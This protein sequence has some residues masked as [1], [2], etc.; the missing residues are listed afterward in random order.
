G[1]PES[2]PPKGVSAV[3][4]DVTNGSFYVNYAGGRNVEMDICPQLTILSGGPLCTCGSTCPYTSTARGLLACPKDCDCQHLCKPSKSRSGF[5]FTVSFCPT[6]LQSSTPKLTTSYSR[7]STSTRR[8]H[9]NSMCD[10]PSLPELNRDPRY[11]SYRPC[12]CSPDK[13]WLDVV[14]VLDNSKNMG[15][16]SLQKITARIITTFV[17]VPVGQKLVHQTR[18]GIV[19]YNARAKVVGQLTKYTALDGMQTDLAYLA[20]TENNHVNI[21]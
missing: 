14:L 5:D 11:R 7:P 10:P 18:V 8:P 20:P 4:F 6:A 15:P 3:F 2:V 9:Y 17:D 13:L 19:T 12:S 1:S 21:Y 16:T